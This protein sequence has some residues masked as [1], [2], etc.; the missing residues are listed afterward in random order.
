M[1]SRNVLIMISPMSPER[2]NGIAR[3]ARER[4]WHM[5]S[6]DRLL[7]RLSGW[8][9]DGALVTLRNDPDQLRIVR[10]LI[11]RGIPVVDLTCE[12]P[13]IK[14][15]RVIGDH[16]SIGQSAGRH[17]IERN[18][19]NLVWFS[20]AYTNV[21]DLRYRGLMDVRDGRDVRRLVVCEALGERKRD[22][23]NTISRW[24]GGELARAPKPLGVVC[25]DDSDAARVADVCRAYGLSIPEEVAILG[26]GNDTF[27][28]EYQENPLSSVIHNS[29]AT[30]YEGAKLLDRL[31]DGGKSPQAPVLI[32]P[33]GIVIRKSTETIAA[34]DPIV[35]RALNYIDTHLASS[36]GIAQIAD[37]L[38]MT[39][40]SL[41][42]LFKKHLGRRVGDEIRRERIAK[43]KI[44]LQ[45][46]ELKICSIAKETGFCNL[47]HFTRTFKQSCGM[48]PSAYRRR[49]KSVHGVVWQ[50]SP[51]IPNG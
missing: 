41:H 37:E 27:I 42:R 36:F 14:V 30:G 15:P 10:Q 6:T 43:A 38:D 7:H 39:A 34:A 28:C 13:E 21:H 45:A 26:I 44:L 1:R 31:M 47:A 35:R 5:M 50:E 51:A 48:V 33:R 12:H 19:S 24:L 8:N 3:F 16:F 23:W 25:Y 22:D 49:S 29:E 9:G 17:F 4:H 2:L 18:F 32:P 46:T 11:R 40:I 20:S